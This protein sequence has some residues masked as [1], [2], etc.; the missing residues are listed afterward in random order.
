MH[1]L[2]KAKEDIFHQD[3][4]HKHIEKRV[5]EYLN[6]KRWLTNLMECP[7]LYPDLNPTENLWKGF[8]ANLRKIAHKLTNLY[9]LLVALEEE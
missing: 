3:N 8:D 5:L 1:T 4:K 6:E 7:V 9:Q 2:Q